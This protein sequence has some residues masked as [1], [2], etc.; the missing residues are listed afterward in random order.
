M[1]LH[2]DGGYLG[3]KPYAA[4]GKY[5]DRM[6]D[7]CKGCRFEVKD[8]TGPDACPLNALYWHFLME[9]EDRLASNPRMGLVYRS[10][11]RFSPERRAELKAKATAT[12]G[13]W[14]IAGGPDAARAASADIA[15]SGVSD[16]TGPGQA[17]RRMEP[18]A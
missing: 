13:E 10:L 15:S 7:Y 6:S 1:V 16:D 18:S 14:G 8:S 9:N 4:S 3:S 11:A 17:D 2:A 5:I 12:L